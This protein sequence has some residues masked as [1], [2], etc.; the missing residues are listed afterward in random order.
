MAGKKT[1]RASLLALVP[2]ASLCPSLGR[3]LEINDTWIGPS[4]GN[5]SV[6]TNWD[7]GV[8]PGNTGPVLFN[9]IIP[10][11]GKYVYFDKVKDGV[12]DCTVKTFSLG[13]ASTFHLLP[14]T[15]YTVQEQADLYGIL[16]SDGGKFTAVG[17]GAGLKG[18]RARISIWNGAVVTIGGDTYSSKGIWQSW[19][20][21]WHDGD[22]QG[23][24]YPT[25]MAADG[26]GTVLDLSKLVKIDA[27]FS[28]GGNDLNLQ[29]ITASNG[30][31]IDLSGVQTLTAPAAD[32]DQIGFVVSGADSRVKLDK[33]QTIASAGGGTTWFSGRTL[34]HLSGGTKLDLTALTSSNY[35]G[36]VLLDGSEVT[37]PAYATMADTYFNL[38]GGS[39]LTAGGA[40]GVFSSLATWNSW[41]P[42]W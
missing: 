3:A 14:G 34:F 19:D 35:T 16:N 32:R 37:A 31:V 29:R 9:V 30:G 24:W 1:R 18:E 22:Q 25:L 12:L 28:S 13:D 4:G 10:G 17:P 8:V 6:P 7:T 41:D 38:S 21:D 20:P 26:A 33:L 11:G 36:L 40:N 5:Y 15:T 27:G 42:D 39:K 2:L 23:T